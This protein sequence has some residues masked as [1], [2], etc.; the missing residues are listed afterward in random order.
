MEPYVGSAGKRT[1][2]KHAMREA[3]LYNPIRLAAVPFGCVLFRNNTGVLQDRHGQYVRYGL[4]VGSSDLIGWTTHHG[5]A[6]FTAIE[7]K[8]PG[9]KT[10]KEQDAFLLAVRHAG[11]IGLCVHSVEEF[12]ELM[13]LHTHHLLCSG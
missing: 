8:R 12:E 13:R 10:T 6:M 2:E 7:V 11:G 5:L 9:K 1:P 4:G 3:D